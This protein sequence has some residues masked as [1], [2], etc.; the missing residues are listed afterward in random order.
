MPEK[1]KVNLLKEWFP[2]LIVVHGL[3]YAM[4]AVRAAWG[5]MS[6]YLLVV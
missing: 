4:Y 1:K 6:T 3:R 2:F 5:L